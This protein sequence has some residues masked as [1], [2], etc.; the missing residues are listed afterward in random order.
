MGKNIYPAIGRRCRSAQLGV[1]LPCCLSPAWQARTPVCRLSLGGV[2][3]GRLI[4]RRWWP[5]VNLLWWLLVYAGLGLS[6][7]T[8]CC[9]QWGGALLYIALVAIGAC[10]GVPTP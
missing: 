9:T 10:A 8:R 1:H 7:C 5:P 2:S 6:R 3:Q 4:G